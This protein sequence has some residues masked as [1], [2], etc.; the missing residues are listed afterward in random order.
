M[1]FSFVCA[2]IILWVTGIVAYKIREKSWMTKKIYQAGKLHKVIGY[3]FIFAGFFT[4]AFGI[5]EWIHIYGSHDLE[6][7]WIVNLVITFTF[8]TLIETC[9]RRKRFG[10][11]PFVAPNKTMTIKEFE[12]N[13][14]KGEKLW[15]LDNLILDLSEY[16][17]KHPGGQFVMDRT[18]GKDVSKFFYGGYSLDSNQNVVK[19]GSAHIWNHTN[20]ARKIVN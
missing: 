20:I 10:K 19:S 6:K 7:L 9:N 2:V 3:F 14:K 4:V 1:G 13:I 15:I 8:Y 18:V 16:S 17:K 11:D 12:E 5:H